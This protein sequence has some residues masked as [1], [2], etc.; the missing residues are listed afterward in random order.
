MRRRALAAGLAAACLAALCAPAAAS[1]HGLLSR[2][3]GPI[4]DWLF[5]WA[6]A[7][8]L[9]GSF[10]ALASLWPTP[11]LQEPGARRLFTLPR[12]VDPLCGAIGVALFA[13][14][15][16]AGFA[17]NQI[18]M[19]NI[20]PAFVYRVF[21]I[22]PVLLGALMGNVFGAFNPW[23]A[24]ARC[25]AWVARRIGGG[26]SP[27]PLPYPPWL[28][29]W[30]A[31]LGILA[32]AWVEL[33]YV[34]RAEPSTLAVMALA[35]AATQ[36]VG[37]SLYGI[38]TWTERADPF[39]V[40]FGLFAR[41]SPLFR[42][43]REVLARR[44]LSGITTLDV[45]PGTIPLLCVMIGAT[46]FDGFSQGSLWSGVSAKS[47][48]KPFLTEHV[49]GPLGLGVN[50]TSEIGDTLGLLVWVLAVAGIYRLGVRGMRSVEGGPPARDLAATFAHTL[51]PI[52][53]AYVVAH[54]FTALVIDGQSVALLASDPLGRGN[55]P[56]GQISYFLNANAIW[57]IQV[58]ALVLGHVG[59]IVLA[60]DRALAVYRDARQATRSQCW[61]LCVMVG[62]T[63]LGLWLLSEASQ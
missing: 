25:V 59:G 19:N 9:V 30:P 39:A 23:R 60:H 45:L 32:F 22:G 46:A 48:I 31:A 44:P 4:P 20:A 62:F 16:Y 18:P 26:E 58:G 27:E 6:A 57:Y 61:M 49:V 8:V 28:G 11:R 5:G 29:R 21:W 2:Q 33:I 63:S 40:Y 7:L 42:R 15:V 38:D 52:A 17:G 35:Y 13:L 51:L 36:L 53:F 12:W 37:M 1:A 50:V 43:G 14:I 3:Y 55:D 34:D 10:L 41:L 47:G 24:I 56:G 54:Y